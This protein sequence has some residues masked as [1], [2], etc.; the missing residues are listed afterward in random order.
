M[1][2]FPVTVFLRSSVLRTP[3]SSPGALAPMP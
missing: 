1:K 2:P 3:A